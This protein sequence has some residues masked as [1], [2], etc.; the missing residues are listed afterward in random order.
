M[1]LGR[2]VAF[3]PSTPPRSW[4]HSPM[5]SSPPFSNESSWSPNSSTPP[6]PP[7]RNPRTP[8]HWPY[9]ARTC[10]GRRSAYRNA[11]LGRRAATRRR[12]WPSAG[13]GDAGTISPV[14]VLRPLPCRQQAAPSRSP[15]P[16]RFLPCVGLA[17]AG[18][19]GALPPGRV[20]GPAGQRST[21]PLALCEMV[22]SSAAY[23]ADPI[24]GAGAVPL[25]LRP[26]RTGSPRIATSR[27][28]AGGLGMQR[29]RCLRLPAHA[30][31]RREVG[32]QPVKDLRPPPL[33]PCWAQRARIAGRRTS[34]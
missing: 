1:G 33:S 17:A 11:Q 20:R 32:A 22:A 26:V 7:G 23:L 29:S 19:V 31:G 5:G 25:R 15:F 8:G 28:R 14:R 3:D 30:A 27:A 10:P 2:G 18:L 34:Q 6:A 21:S 16:G 12:G 9:R 24:G 4:V 13:D